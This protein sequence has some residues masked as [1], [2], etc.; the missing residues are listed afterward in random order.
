MTK[1]IV[2]SEVGLFMIPLEISELDDARVDMCTEAKQ[3]NTFA[4]TEGQTR[5]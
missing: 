4:K 2:E 3:M 1:C 5:T